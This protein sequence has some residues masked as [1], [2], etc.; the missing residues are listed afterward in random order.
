[1]IP[2]KMISRYSLI[3]SYTA[4]GTRKN[5]SIPSIPKKTAIFSMTVRPPIKRKEAAI[6]FFSVSSSRSP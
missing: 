1:M 4:S 2:A 5:Q 3:I 6:L